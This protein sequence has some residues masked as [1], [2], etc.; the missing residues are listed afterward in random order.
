MKSIIQISVKPCE[1][2]SE[3]AIADLKA[4]VHQLD[5]TARKVAG[6][7]VNLATSAGDNLH[8]IKALLPHGQF[9]KWCDENIEFSERTRQRYMWFSTHRAVIEALRK[10]N[11]QLT[12]MEIVQE[13]TVPK[14]PRLADLKSNRLAELEAKV[15]RCVESAGRAKQA[16][17]NV[18]DQKLWEGD[19]DSIDDWCRS[20]TGMT[21]EEFYT[22][23]DPTGGVE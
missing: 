1:L 6:Q 11:P 10:E 17:L 4:R 22:L 2:S 14:P 21:F 15:S 23:C 18:R 12:A 9:G 16:L 13:L 7:Y 5:E 20:V 19:F 8:Q 3:A